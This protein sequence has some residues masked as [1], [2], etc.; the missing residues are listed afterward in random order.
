M[1]KNTTQSDGRSRKG[2]DVAFREW[3]AKLGPDDKLPRGRC[4]SVRAASTQPAMSQE[5]ATPM[6]E[7]PAIPVEPVVFDSMPE[8]RSFGSFASTWE[9]C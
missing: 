9:P 7:M 5:T 3:A 6:E 1:H 2:P 4:R 8:H